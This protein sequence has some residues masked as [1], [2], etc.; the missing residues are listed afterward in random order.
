MVL[1]RISKGASLQQDPHN[2][3]AKHLKDL[4]AAVRKMEMDALKAVE[5]GNCDA[6]YQHLDAANH[7][8]SDSLTS[9]LIGC[10]AEIRTS[11]LDE[12]L[13]DVLEIVELSDDPDVLHIAALC[14]YHL[15][16]LEEASDI[17]GEALE[18]KPTSSPSASPLARHVGRSTMGG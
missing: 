15:G 8:C 11:H 18:R 16:Q 3:T 14:Y 9:E 10:Y 2:T 7:L 17:F 4:V 5:R 6:A 12:C 13:H 1:W